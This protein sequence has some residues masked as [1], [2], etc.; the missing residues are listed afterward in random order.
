MD[1]VD[2]TR[3]SIGSVDLASRGRYRH[4][5]PSSTSMLRAPTKLCAVKGAS[6]ELRIPSRSYSL[7]RDSMG[8]NNQSSMYYELAY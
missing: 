2:D 6:K 4:C 5:S 3:R 7:A 8:V 1:C